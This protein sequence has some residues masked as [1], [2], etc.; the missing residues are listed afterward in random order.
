MGDLT[1]HCPECKQRNEL[2]DKLGDT[3]PAWLR[4]HPARH[5]IGEQFDQLSLWGNDEDR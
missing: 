4:Q 1:Y 2:A 5:L 3:S